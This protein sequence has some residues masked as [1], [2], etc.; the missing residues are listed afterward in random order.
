M[1]VISEFEEAK[2]FLN[3]GCCDN[4]TVGGLVDS[5]GDIL[6]DWL[7]RLRC[8]R[9]GWLQSKHRLETL[10]QYVDLLMEST[11]GLIHVVVRGWNVWCGLWGFAR[12]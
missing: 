9:R 6:R 11:D 1:W 3:A 7:R 8:L 10:F 2:D 5:H 4:H 12:S